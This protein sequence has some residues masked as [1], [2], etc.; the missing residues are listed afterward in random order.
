M[1]FD[2]STYTVNEE[3]EELLVGL[4]LTNPSH[5]EIFFKV[6]T[7]GGTAIGECCVIDLLCVHDKCYDNIISYICIMYRVLYCNLGVKN[8]SWVAL[9]HEN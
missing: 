7:S 2:Q 1:R 5:Q 4:S 9:T 6:T 3:E 8:S